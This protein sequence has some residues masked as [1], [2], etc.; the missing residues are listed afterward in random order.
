MAKL[1]PK[2]PKGPGQFTKFQRSGNEN[3]QIAQAVRPQLP[4]DKTSE[5]RP[6]YASGEMPKGGY[7]SMWTF[8]GRSDTK[9][10]PTTK[11]GQK[12]Y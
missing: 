1:T 7:Q 5:G 3:Q 4:R 9:N 2:V 12:V 11:P 8:D 10:S 6:T